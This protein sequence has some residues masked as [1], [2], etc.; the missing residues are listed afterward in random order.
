MNFNCTLD[1]FK[2]PGMTDVDLPFGTKNP[3]GVPIFDDEAVMN[4]AMVFTR[5]R[6]FIV[7]ENSLTSQIQAHSLFVFEAANLTL[8]LGAGGFTGCQVRVIN[9]SDGVS[10]VVFGETTTA[11]KA[12]QELAFSWNGTLWAVSKG[13][14]AGDTDTPDGFAQYQDGRNLLEVL[15]VATPEEAIALLCERCNNGTDAA[16]GEPD[17]SGLQIGDYI[18][19]IDLSAIP[20][21]NSGT[22]GQVY[23]DEYRNNDIVISGFNTYLGMGDTENRKN[24]ILFT[25]RNCPIRKRM[26]S[27][28][29]NTGGYPA[30][31]LRAFLEGASGN[32]TGAKSGVT[33]AAFMNALIGQI[34]N[35]LY[36]VRRATST[37]SGSAWNSYT[38]F[39]PTEIEVFGV[40]VYGDEGVY[41]TA[42]TS[43]TVAARAG[44]ITPIHFPIF[45]KSYKYIIK[46]NNGARDWWF[47]S[48]PYAAAASNFCDV[49]YIGNAGDNVASAVGGLAPAF[50]VA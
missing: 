49:H 25:F 2:V 6:P 30:S 11:L 19:G 31:E 43:P 17:F 40:P 9:V 26:N 24:H 44:W 47:E 20:A 35:H 48:T 15:D 36:T 7:N 46:R 5:Q 8:T 3:N 41:M 10:S 34:G 29:D 1:S 22:A 45:Q 4:A 28:N 18:P 27:S 14:G 42:L 39:L 16:N 32:G 38:V 21:E 23:S 12:G 33:T 13:G 37:K 50:C